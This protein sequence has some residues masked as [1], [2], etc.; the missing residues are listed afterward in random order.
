LCR[1]AIDGIDHLSKNGYA[2]RRQRTS[3]RAGGVIP[4][5]AGQ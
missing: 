3:R 1:S 5:D 2:F 4:P